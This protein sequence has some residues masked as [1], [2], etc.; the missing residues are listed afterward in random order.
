M[1]VPRQALASDTSG[2]VNQ[3]RR[4]RSAIIS[5]AQAILDRGD[6]PSVAQAAEEALV[7]RTTAYRYFPTQEAL[8]LELSL[9]IDVQDVAAFVASPPPELS[10]RERVLAMLRLFNED[11]FGNESLHRASIRF[12]M[13]AW[14]AAE[15]A[16]EE[17]FMVREGRRTH[18]IATLLKPLRGT[19]SDEDLDR[20]EAGLCLTCGGEAMTVMRDVCGLDRDAALG[21]LAWVAQA[22]LD[23]VT[24]ETR[25]RE[26][27]K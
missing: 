26:R 2:R 24:H 17:N 20:L 27:R 7:S 13:D 21:V 15:R 22:L 11:I 10:P 5:A 8:L 16:G 23:A 25:S 18:Y 14:L 9:N 19:I 4:T 6:T 3:K 12:F 1:A